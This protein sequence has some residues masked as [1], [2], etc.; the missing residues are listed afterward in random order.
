MKTQTLPRHVWAIKLTKYKAPPVASPT[1]QPPT[2]SFISILYNCVVKENALREQ[3]I[4]WHM[5]LIISAVS[6]GHREWRTLY[7]TSLNGE[8]FPSLSFW[9]KEK[10]RI[11]VATNLPPFSPSTVVFLSDYRKSMAAVSVT[12]ATAWR[13]HVLKI[14]S[15]P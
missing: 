2:F 14:Q 13:G 3:I 10:G 9:L 12:S 5:N 15:S 6:W 1:S 11:M 7:L 8:P 4:E